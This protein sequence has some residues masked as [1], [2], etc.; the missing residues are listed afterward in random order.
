MRVER[1]EDLI[2]W[3]KARVLTKDVYLTTMDPRFERDFALCGQIRKSAISVPSN[4]AEGFERGGRREF[5]QFLSVAKGS[6]AEL[7]TQIYIAADVGYIDDSTAKRLLAEA[8]E[9]GKIIG[10]LRKAVAKQRT[11]SSVLSPQS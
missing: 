1:F 9:V 7:R 5:H 2:A 6:C 10:G 8:A 11:Q 4:I 3:Q